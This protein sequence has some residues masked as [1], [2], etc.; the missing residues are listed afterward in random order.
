MDRSHVCA[1][2][3]CLVPAFLFVT[4]D[5]AEGRVTDCCAVAASPLPTLR[6]PRE[7]V[8]EVGGQ[9]KPARLHAQSVVSAR[10]AVRYAVLHLCAL[11]ELT[12][13]C[14][15]A[16]D[17]SHV[18]AVFT[19]LV[20]AFLFVTGDTAEGRVTDCCAVAASPLPTLRGTRSSASP[21]SLALPHLG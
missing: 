13:S 15:E 4:G 3:T 9:Q 5:T 18:C 21:R 19:C 7:E 12:P 20:P 6:Y 16:V 11:C 10:R 8:G 1:V 17:R 14:A 2:F